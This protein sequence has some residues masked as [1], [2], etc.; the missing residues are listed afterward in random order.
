MRISISISL[1]GPIKKKLDRFSKSKHCDR[2][3]VIQEA[4][5]Q[6]LTREEFRRLRGLMVPK[7]EKQGIFSDEDV[8]RKIS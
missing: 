4:L 6:F 8:F 5:R 3:S 1:P 2:S 7:A